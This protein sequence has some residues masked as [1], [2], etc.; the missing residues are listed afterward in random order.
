MR[1]AAP[2][3]LGQR[4]ATT[5]RAA[6]ASSSGCALDVDA[7]PRRAPR[8]SRAGSAAVTAERLGQGPVQLADHRAEPAGVGG[9]VAAALLRA[10]AGGRRGRAAR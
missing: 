3:S 2:G 7:G 10:A 5:Y 1:M 4:Q 6:A 8:P 9:E